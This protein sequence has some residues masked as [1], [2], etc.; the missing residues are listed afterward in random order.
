MTSAHPSRSLPIGGRWPGRDI[1]PLVIVLLALLGG[2]RVVVY[3]VAWV[4]VP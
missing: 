2:S 4:I 3:L 1:V